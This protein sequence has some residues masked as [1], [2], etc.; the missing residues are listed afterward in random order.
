MVEFEKQTNTFEQV[1]NDI[2]AEKVDLF[3]IFEKNFYENVQNYLPET[4]KN[5]PNIEIYY[6]SINNASQD[7]YLYFVNLFN[8]F[9]SAIA[10]KF[11]INRELD[12]DYDLATE[13]QTTI[14]V[15]TSVLPFLL[16]VFLFTASM[17][18][19]PDTIAGEKERGTI[20]T[21]LVTPMKR[22]ELALGKII[23]ISIAALSSSFVSF[24]GIILSLPKLMSTINVDLSIYGFDTYLALFGVIVITELLFVAII[25]LISSIARSVKEASGFCSAVMILVMLLGMTTMLGVSNSSVLSYFI[26]AYN[27]IQCLNEILSLSFNPLHFLITII[28]NI[29]YVLLGVLLIAKVFNS[30]KMLN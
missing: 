24:L 25:S 23:A 6:N 14:M 11:D 7:A 3:V 17:A 2:K 19:T 21:L 30:E 9:E 29:I 27:S 18:I 15:L 22:S 1:K 10:N 5:A 20:A 12:M 8:E 26:P 13:E 4:G 16:I 28:A